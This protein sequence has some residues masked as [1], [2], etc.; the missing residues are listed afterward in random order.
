[1]SN[2]VTYRGTNNDIVNDSGDEK[3]SIPKKNGSTRLILVSLVVILALN[4]AISYAQT[5]TL[6]WR[7]TLLDNKPPLKEG[8]RYFTLEELAKYDDSDPNLPIYMSIKGQVFDVTSGKKFYGKGQTYNF[9]T[10]K[11]A[12]RSL[13]SGCFDES[14]PLGWADLTPEEEKE[15]DWHVDFY[16]THKTYKFVGYLI[17]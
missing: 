11:D 6:F 16:R 13:K 1:M 3:K 4:S 2:K 5:K 10:G 9:F 12:T 15:F 8:E 7:F 14:C 17:V